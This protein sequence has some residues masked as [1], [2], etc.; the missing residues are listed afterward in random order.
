VR[1]GSG[2][3]VT[4][5]EAFHELGLEDRVA[6]DGA[7]HCAVHSGLAE[8]LFGGRGPGLPMTEAKEAPMREEGLS[9]FKACAT[10][11]VPEDAAPTHCTWT[12]SRKAGKLI[13]C[14]EPLPCKKHPDASDD[15]KA[16]EAAPNTVPDLDGRK[17]KTDA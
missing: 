12:V 9:K 14:G 7:R 4:G 17:G 16:A 3:V 10:C 11:S 2:V 15:E 5:R 6:V 1:K 13:P 8:A